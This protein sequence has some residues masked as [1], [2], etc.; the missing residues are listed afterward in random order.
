MSSLYKHY[1]VCP[2]RSHNKLRP[3]CERERERERERDRQTERERE[4]ERDR[5]R[6]R[7][8]EVFVM[9]AV[10]ASINQICC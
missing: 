8:R 4:R 6:E 7:E 10:P 1:V 5:E 3:P 2:P 9:M